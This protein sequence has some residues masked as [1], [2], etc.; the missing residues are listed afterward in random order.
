MENDYKHAEKQVDII[1]FDDTRIY[2]IIIGN[3]ENHLIFSKP[4]SNR[5][6]RLGDTGRAPVYYSQCCV[7]HGGRTMIHWKTINDDD[8]REA[9]RQG[10]FPPSVIASSGQVALILTQGW[11]PQWAALKQGLEK[12]SRDAVPEI[13]V[14]VFIYDRSP[15]FYDF[16]DFKESVWKND[17]IPYVRYYRDG[18]FRAD[19]NF[20]MSDRFFGQFTE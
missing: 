4:T 12:K 16:L 2:D 1:F 13:D 19:S 10:E 6:S 7:P 15:L 18:I 17:V 9:I 3:G 14:H 20:V 11:C 5:A 8:A